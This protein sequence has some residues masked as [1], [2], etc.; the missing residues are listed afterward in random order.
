MVGICVF[1]LIGSVGCNSIW[2][3]FLDP[4]QVGRF[5]GPPVTMEIKRSIS[6]AD[7]PITGLIPEATEPTEEDIKVVNKD[8]ILRPGDIIDISIFELLAPGVP[9]VETRQISREGYVTLPQIRR[10]IKA[11]GKTTRELEKYIA[12]ILQEEQILTEPD[13]TVVIR[14]PRNMVY[15][16]LGAVNG[17]GASIIPRPDFRLLDAIAA[18]GG[19]ALPGGTKQPMVRMIYV[20]RREEKNSKPTE[21]KSNNASGEALFGTVSERQGLAEEG[22]WIWSEGEWKYVKPTPQ[23]KPA[24][25]QPATPK[26]KSAKVQKPKQPAKQ[27]PQKAQ[28]KITK[29]EEIAEAIPSQRIIAIPI[30]K[31]ESGDPRYNIIIREGDTI[32][33]PPTMQGEFYIMGNVLR[34]GVYSLTGREITLKQAIAA[35]GGLGPIA[36]PSRCELIRRI[37]GDK[38]QIITV[39]LDAIFAGKE[40]DIILKPDDIVNVGTNPLLP[41]L[42][43][44]RNAFRATYGFGF[45]YDRN[46][47]DIDSYS[48]KTN[49]ADK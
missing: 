19:I 35:A 13:V 41:F 25:T 31:L 15:N 30:D 48:S 17:P 36:D 24:E 10:D 42:A 27:I 11:A 49:P 39:D 34:P 20:F 4:S 16:I 44:L 33:I 18:A 8:Y 5:S 45:V 29:W 6:I 28:K 2:N 43:V 14:D 9:W 37:G 12:K 47:A 46:F 7:E 23:T 26:T 38:E 21:E 40:P 3:G 22:Y 1:A 32:W